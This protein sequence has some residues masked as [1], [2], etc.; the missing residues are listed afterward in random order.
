[1]EANKTAVPNERAAFEDA[2]FKQC[3]LSTIMRNPSPP[4]PR[5]SGC[6]DFIATADKTKAELCAKNSDGSYV[7]ESLNPAWWAWQERGTAHEELVT[8]LR[9]DLALFSALSTIAGCFTRSVVTE[10]NER[11]AG[12]EATLTK[13]GA[14]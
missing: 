9:A 2:A 6:M 1:M 11:I 8:G 7:E 14:A 12:I 4:Q 5:I 13:A 10:I 3:L